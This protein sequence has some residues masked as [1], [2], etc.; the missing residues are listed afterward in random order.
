M[1]K[2]RKNS[3]KQVVTGQLSKHRKGFGFVAWNED[4]KD[5]YIGERNMG[6]AMDG[7]LVNVELLPAETWR[8]M[9]G[10]RVDDSYRP[11]RPEGRIVSIRKRKITE[12]AGT[13]RRLPKGRKYIGCVLPA[14][15]DFRGEIYVTGNG[16]I[17]ICDG[18]RVMVKLEKYPGNYA[19]AEGTITELISGFNEPGGDIRLIARSFGMRED[20]PV[21]ARSE[22]KALRNE[23]VSRGRNLAED[24]LK[25]RKDLR[26]ETIFSIDGEDSKDFDDAVSIGLLPN[27]NYR[28][29]IHIADVSHYVTEGSA[30]DSEALRR[31]T[32]VYLLDQVI[33]MLP[34]ELSNDLCS[35][36]PGEDR[37]TLSLDIEVDKTGDVA[38]HEIYE[39]VICSK[40]RLVYDEVSDMLEGIDNAGKMPSKGLI[41]GNYDDIE[42]ALFIMKDLAEVL[43]NKKEARGSVDFD[44]EEAS[45]VLDEKGVPVNIGIQERRTANRLIEEFMLLANEVIA[46]H[47]RWLEVPFVYRGHEKPDADKMQQLRMFLQ[48]FDIPFRSSTDKVHPRTISGI[49]E[50]VKGSTFEN[51]IN[52]ATLRSMQKAYYSTSCDGHF[53]LALDSYCHFTSPIR[54]YPDLM[55]HRIIKSVINDG[56]SRKSFKHFEE[57]VQ[58]TAD[59]SSA[60]ERRAIEAEREVEK[61]K[62]AEYMAGHIGQVYEGII[63]GVTGFGIFVELENTIEGLVNIEEL[64]DD[65]YEHIPE[66]YMLQGTYTGKQYRL[67][68]RVVVLVE[69]VDIG[70]REINFCLV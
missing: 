13:F 6:S 30:M 20:F 12:V 16:G 25:G 57:I 35:L 45:I 47:F 34:K 29:G 32:S 44:I 37:L 5:I 70:R 59:D 39:S 68:D 65:Y 36:K 17:D 56:P 4:E 10:I 27:G 64:F 63:S 14:G 7:D 51:V 43:R 62:K 3:K 11:A 1:K 22:A 24:E 49:L 41:V 33:S 53:G 48:S 55:V 8:G 2:A 21:K 67:G 42:K 19:K 18:D 58:K 9:S 54:R 23:Y 61:L 66:M 50:S 26:G 15:R 69:S 31:G 28:L 52:T 38:G 40:A 46:E 60:A